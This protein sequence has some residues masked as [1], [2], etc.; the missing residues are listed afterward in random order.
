MKIN[1]FLTHPLIQQILKGNLT[2]TEKERW[3]KLSSEHKEEIQ[4]YFS[5]DFDQNEVAEITEA[6][7]KIVPTQGHSNAQIAHD[8]VSSETIEIAFMMIAIYV[9][10]EILKGFFNSIGSDLKEKLVQAL[11]SKKKPFIQF[12]MFYKNC[13]I[14]INANPENKEEWSRIF[15]TIDKAG[16]M[17]IN[18]IEK[19]DKMRYGLI[20]N[21]DINVDGYWRLE[22]V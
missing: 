14:D 12:K 1:N 22:K 10:G 3:F 4:I 7:N 21:Y 15:D 8:S 17:A 18:E 16:I 13:R 11:K 20:V 19:D 9:G 2:E 5:N 6:F